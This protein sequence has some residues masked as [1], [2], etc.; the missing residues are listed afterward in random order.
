MARRP[1]PQP[2]Q[3]ANLTLSQLEQGIARLQK[4]LESVRS[5]DPAEIRE[6]F[7]S[8]ILEKLSASVEDG[9][10]RTFGHDTVEYRR[11]CGATSFST[12]PIFMNRD[13]TYTDLQKALVDSKFRSIA[14]LEQAIESLQEQVA[15]MGPIEVISPV[16][17]AGKISAR[18]LS[19]KVFIVHGHDDGAREAVARFLEKIGFQAVILHEQAN[20]GKTVIEKVEANGEVGFAVVLLTPDDEGCARGGQP[21]SRVRQNVLLELGYFIGRLG[22]DKVCAL[23]RGDPDIPSDFAGV[24]WEAMDESGGWRQNLARELEAAGHSVDWNTVM[25]L[26]AH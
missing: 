22:R 20:R 17:L 25:R 16:H 26:N 5:F 9:L 18:D 2:P 4:R 24:V 14:L 7:G 12:G 15:D 19:R 21:V 1:T 8:P 6:Q 3:P 23:R 13:A 11:Y 10:V